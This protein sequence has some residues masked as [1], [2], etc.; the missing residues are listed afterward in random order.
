M[1]LLFV[2][3]VAFWQYAKSPTTNQRVVVGSKDFT[4]SALL[5]EILAQM[6]EARGVM[7]NGASN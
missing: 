5:A 4:E 2:A 7:L 1:A 3:G 6:L